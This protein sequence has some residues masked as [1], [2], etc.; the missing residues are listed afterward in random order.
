M[1]FK[2]PLK[3]L[4]SALMCVYVTSLAS[5]YCVHVQSVGQGSVQL[6]PWSKHRRDVRGRAACTQASF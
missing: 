1:G 6:E 2:Q 5:M 3:K 4:E